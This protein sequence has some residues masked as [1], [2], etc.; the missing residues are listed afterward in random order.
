M[1]ETIVT[2]SE[3]RG[4]KTTKKKKGRKT[5]GHNWAKQRGETSNRRDSET[6]SATQPREIGARSS[7]ASCMNY[8]DTNSKPAGQHGMTARNS[9]I[10]EQRALS[11]AAPSPSSA[12]CCAAPVSV[13]SWFLLPFVGTDTFDIRVG[14]CITPAW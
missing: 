6:T 10:Q 1:D 13:C 8:G 5:I 7:P 2:P 3:Q 9:E 4:K 12:R 11:A 14:V